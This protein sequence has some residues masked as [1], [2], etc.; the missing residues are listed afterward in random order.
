MLLDLFSVEYAP[1]VTTAPD[2]HDLPRRKKHISKEK[3]DA[4][5]ANLLL[6]EQEKLAYAQALREQI[7]SIINPTEEEPVIIQGVT[8]EP[9][10]PRSWEQD[11]ANR[12][13]ELEGKLAVAELELKLAQEEA[14]Q[15]RIYMKKLREEDDIQAIMLALD[16]PFQSLKHTI[17]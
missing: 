3:I 17:H 12:F 15:H 5:N 4:I 14:R 8:I 10:K 7:D 16:A 6:K 11:R 13:R 1:A 2:T 9:L